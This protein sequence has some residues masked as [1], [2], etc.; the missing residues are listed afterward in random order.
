MQLRLIDGTEENGNIFVVETVAEAGSVLTSH[1][2]KHSH[3]S[4]L[5]SG[6]AEVEV[7]GNTSTYSGYNAITVPKDCVHEVRALTDIVWLCL[8]DNELAPREEAEQA[9]KLV[10]GNEEIR[11][12]S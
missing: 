4:I 9:L 1:Q 12:A 8:W 2:H 3:L 11:A 5:V 7:D 6:V 10:N